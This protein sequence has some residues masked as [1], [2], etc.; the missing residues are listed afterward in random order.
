MRNDTC[1]TVF[2][3]DDDTRIYRA[4]PLQSRM[5]Q[6]EGGGYLESYLSYG[7]SRLNVFLS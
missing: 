2:I 4:R 7:S 3:I 1:R 5:A 6:F